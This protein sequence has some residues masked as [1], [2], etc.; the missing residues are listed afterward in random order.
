MN[1]ISIFDKIACFFFFTDGG[2]VAVGIK[3][4]N[5]GK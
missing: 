2:K 4:K 3:K 1:Q 5:N